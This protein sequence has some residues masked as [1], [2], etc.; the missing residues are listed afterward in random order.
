MFEHVLAETLFSQSPM[1]MA[2]VSVPDYR[3]EMANPPQT[4]FY[5]SLGVTDFIG[6]RW[7]DLW[8]ADSFATFLDVLNEV[9]STGQPRTIIDEP[10]DVVV[11]GKRRTLYSSFSYYPVFGSSG[12]VEHIVWFGGDTTARMASKKRERAAWIAAEQR[13]SAME[14]QLRAVSLLH[15][16]STKAVGHVDLG[17]VMSGILEAAV[18]ITN[19]EW[20][21]IQ[22]VD[23]ATDA[24]QMVAG[25][26]FDERFMNGFASIRRG[27]HTS[28]AAAW[29]RSERV[30]IED[31]ELSDIMANS[32]EL[33]MYR[34]AGVRAVQST[35]IFSPSG[36][37]LG[38]LSTHYRAPVEFSGDMLK[39]VDVLAR[40]TGDIIHWSRLE[41]ERRSAQLK[42]EQR[43]AEWEALINASPDAVYITDENGLMLE[44]NPTWRRLSGFPLGEPL[45]RASDLPL[46]VV[47]TLEGH[48]ITAEDLPTARALRGD[49]VVN[50][51]YRVVNAIGQ[52]YELLHNATVVDTPLGKRVF[53]I[54][55]DITELRRLERL[56]DEFML[57]IGHELRNP[58]QVVLG[59]AQLISMKLTP[60]LRP[61]IGSNI[62]S[63]STQ[64][65]L[66]TSLVEDLLNAYRVGH[67]K[68]EVNMTTVDFREVILQTIEAQVSDFEREWHLS[69]TE[70]GVLISA[71]PQRLGQAI[72]NLLTNARKYTPVGGHV[73]V[74]LSCGD[75]GALLTVEDDGQGIPPED[76]EKVFEGFYRTP[77]VA[78]WQSGSIGLGLF[79]SR[80]LTRR[81]GGG[82]WAENRPG[83]GTVMCLKMPLAR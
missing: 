56:K 70:P 59:Q 7:V 14:E 45:P 2:V 74:T 9:S 31:A 48:P 72:T 32:V 35:P 51:R 42:A 53:S 33:E 61:L 50:Y 39:L 46:M 22:I 12:D 71:D 44:A 43:A 37:V 47:T 29:Q 1:R 11:E 64:T 55:T 34:Q 6:R 30:M 82:L 20:G 27:A 65:K 26:G 28:C 68:L 75:D 3:Y 25:F 63:L 17:A 81:M 40:L 69:L 80:S 52:E 13:R 60:E 21:V 5:E 18:H 49:Q 78:K 36:D 54:V 15:S 73:W 79:I 76:L 38:V 62:E 41:A 66:L 67:G 23:A 10:I 58:L 19:A 83:G 8:Q 4:R 77:D 16:V 57:V 24:L